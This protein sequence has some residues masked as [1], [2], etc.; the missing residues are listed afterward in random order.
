MIR[1]TLTALR[2]PYPGREDRLDLSVRD[3][4]ATTRLVVSGSSPR[5]RHSTEA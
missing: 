3:L 5:S 1:E 4:S 2:L